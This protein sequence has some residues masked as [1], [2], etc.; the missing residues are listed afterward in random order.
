LDSAIN[1]V[2]WIVHVATTGETRN[3]CKKSLGKCLL[4]RLKQ[5]MEGREIACEVEEG[6][7]VT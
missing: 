6:T 1:K 2:E 7:E 4:G 3:A 5:E